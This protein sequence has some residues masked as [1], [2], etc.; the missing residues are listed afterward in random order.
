[1]ERTPVT[2]NNL[3]SAGFDEETQTLEVEFKNGSLYRFSGCSL[4]EFQGL[5][6]ADSKGKYF[7]A[8]IRNRYPYI[9]L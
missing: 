4:Q 7:N 1:M 8:N 9:K 3:S 5:M 6:N 2:S